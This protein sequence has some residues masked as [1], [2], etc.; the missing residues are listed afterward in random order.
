MHAGHGVE[1][2]FV[3]H[4]AELGGLHYTDAELALTDLMVTYWTTFAHR[5]NPNPFSSNSSVLE[6]P[7]YQ[8]NFTSDP[9]SWMKFKTPQSE[10][11]IKSTA[12]LAA[13][14]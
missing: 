5:G 7:Q 6:W 11:G 10:V 9:L 4:T 8:L 3:F 14:V 1:L 2:P 12:S 13:A